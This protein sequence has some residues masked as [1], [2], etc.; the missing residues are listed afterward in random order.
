[1][2]A[3]QGFPPLCMKVCPSVLQD[4]I[5]IELDNHRNQLIRVRSH[6]CSIVVPV[7]ARKSSI[8]FIVVCSASQKAASERWH[9]AE[10]HLTATWFAALGANQVGFT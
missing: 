4:Y 7:S 2:N 1:M 6:P 9:A 10:W 5:N 8:G 3:L